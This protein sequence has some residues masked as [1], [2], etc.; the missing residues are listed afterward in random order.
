MSDQ[1]IKVSIWLKAVFIIFSIVLFFA[2]YKSFNTQK[3]E[4]VPTET[5]NNALKIFSQLIDVNNYKDFGF[6][7][8]NDKNNMIAGTQY[9]KYFTEA[10]KITS[11]NGTDSVFQLVNRNYS[12]EIP[13]AYNNKVV[14]SIEFQRNA[15]E[16]W[17]ATGFGY[18]SLFRNFDKQYLNSESNKKVILVDVPSLRNGFYIYRDTT[19][20]FRGNL[21]NKYN[22]DTSNVEKSLS[23]VEILRILK[24]Q[25]EII[26]FR[27][28][29]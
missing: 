22:F 19:N 25:S 1:S 24:K 15:K 28:P 23:D 10:Y 18:S 13:V 5:I 3:D 27:Y 20:S 11:Y 26:D 8:E 4:F 9:K 14:S 6:E 29:D 16:Q 17:E 7:N 21:I 2:F 12:I